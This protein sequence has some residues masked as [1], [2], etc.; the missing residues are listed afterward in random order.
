VGRAAAVSPPA[1]AGTAARGAWAEDAALAFLAGKGLALVERN[2]RCRRG[3]I[4][5]V[6][7]D[8]AVLVFVEVRYRRRGALVGGGESVDGPKQRR[9][10]AS[11]EHFLLHHRAHAGR[12]CRFDVVA[13]SGEDPAP[14]VEWIRDAFRG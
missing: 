8:G 4:D 11:A 10:L 12:A 3:E 7:R 14:R 13:V 2:Y 6:L 5:L 9:L 1:R